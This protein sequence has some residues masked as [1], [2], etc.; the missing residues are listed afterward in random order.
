MVA[1]RQIPQVGQV[2]QLGGD[3]TGQLVEVQEEDLQVG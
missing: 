3:G 2:T 1:I